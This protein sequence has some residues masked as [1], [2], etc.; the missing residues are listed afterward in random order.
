MLSSDVIDANF[1]IQIQWGMFGIYTFSNPFITLECFIVFLKFD[2][3]SQDP[4]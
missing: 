4:A 3:F 1:K 2:M